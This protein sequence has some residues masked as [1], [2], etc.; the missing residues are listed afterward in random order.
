[1]HCVGAVGREDH[2]PH[3]MVRD[4]RL[5]GTSSHRFSNSSNVYDST[6]FLVLHRICVKYLYTFSNT[7]LA[8]SSDVMISITTRILGTE[9]QRIC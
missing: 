2:E 5:R 3:G 7:D 4:Q 8:K 1:M 6:S 9:F